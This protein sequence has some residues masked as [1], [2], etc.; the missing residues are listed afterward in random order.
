MSVNMSEPTKEKTERIIVIM[1]FLRIYTIGS[2]ACG[3]KKKHVPYCNWVAKERI[4]VRFVGLV[5]RR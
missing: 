2:T 4:V 3:K 5:A 1:R